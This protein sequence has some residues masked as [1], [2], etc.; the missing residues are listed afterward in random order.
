MSDHDAEKPQKPVEQLDEN[1]LHA[2]QQQVQGKFIGPA[3]IGAGVANSRNIGAILRIADAINS[4][5][6]VFI[7]TPEFDSR[8]IRKVSRQMSEK[9]AHRFIDFDQF[10]L[11][12]RYYHPLIAVEITTQSRDIYVTHL[13]KNASF[14]VGNE[15]TGIPPKVLAL[16]D[17]AVH[18]PMFGINSSMNVATSLGIVLYEWYRQ[19]QRG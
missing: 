2:R 8:K 9:R 12:V 10:A 17:E 11:Q 7:D 16:C 13:P 5:E 4:R 3:I 1:A 18:I 19:T 14:V 15:R 6:V